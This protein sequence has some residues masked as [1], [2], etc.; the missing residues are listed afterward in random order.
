MKERVEQEGVV[1]KVLHTEVGKE[2]SIKGRTEYG[3][4]KVIQRVPQQKV[5]AVLQKVVHGAVV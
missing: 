4:E 3:I 1:Q 5:A 2:G